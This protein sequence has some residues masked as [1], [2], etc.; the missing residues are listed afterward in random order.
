MEQRRYGL[1]R[2][3]DMGLVEEHMRLEFPN[4]TAIPAGTWRWPHVD[5]AKEWASKG[6]GA[7]VVVPEFLDKFEKLRRMFG[8]P[9]IITSGYR[10]PA[11]NNSVAETGTGGPHTTG[12]A[13]DIRIYG[14]HALALVHLALEIG[15]T[16][17]GLSQKGDQA[18]RFVHLDD[19]LAADGFPRPNLWTY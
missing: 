2:R 3:I 19:L 17:I 9:L 12:R 5:A 18:K 15:F 1:L 10:D 6:N 4:A 7:I 16:G 13:V 8:S 11:Y 14:A